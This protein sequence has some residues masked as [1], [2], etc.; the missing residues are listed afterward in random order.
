MRDKL[1]FESHNLERMNPEDIEYLNDNFHDC[2]EGLDEEYDIPINPTNVFYDNRTAKDCSVICYWGA[3][4]RAKLRDLEF[5]LSIDWI[6]EQISSGKCSVTGIDYQFSEF[7]PFQ[8]SI[9]RIDRHKG[10]TQ[11]NCQAVVLMYNY[12]KNRFTDADVEYF[13]K[14]SKV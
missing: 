4:E 3:K 2:Y 5:N 1:G 11:D 8:P 13:I 6:Y 9:D 10:Y 12:C 7:N 14:N